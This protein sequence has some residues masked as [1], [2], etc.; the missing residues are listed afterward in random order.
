MLGSGTGL[1]EMAGPKG[2][3]RGPLPDNVAVKGGNG[4]PSEPLS[5]LW[6]PVNAALKTPGVPWRMTP[7]VQLP[8]CLSLLMLLMQEL[9]KASTAPSRMGV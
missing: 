9:P 5:A 3:P 4:L 6:L 2:M 8:L 1:E 7:G